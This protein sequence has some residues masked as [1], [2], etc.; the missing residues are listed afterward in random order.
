M[1]DLCIT[2]P[3]KDSKMFFVPSSVAFRSFG[4]SPDRPGPSSDWL[5][6]RGRLWLPAMWQTSL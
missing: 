1:L 3:H 4:F 5:E 2:G 6:G